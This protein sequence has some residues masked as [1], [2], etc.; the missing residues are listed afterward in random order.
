MVLRCL[1]TIFFGRSPR[2]FLPSF[3]ILKFYK[4]KIT[5][6][7]MRECRSGQTG[8]AQDLVAQC[9]RRF[10]PC[11]PHSAP[12]A[13]SGQSTCLLSKVSQVQILPGALKNVQKKSHIK[14]P[15]TVLIKCPF[16]GKR[17][18][19]KTSIER[20]IY[21]IECKGCKKKIQTPIT[22]C[23]LIC[24]FSNKKCPSSLIREAK[25]K[26]LKIK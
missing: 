14:I 18:R 21:F 24:A 3:L 10:E 23:C 13:Q 12:V 5:M 22:R 8:Q 19:I 4:L 15:K 7:F 17:N 26:N 16:C 1:L 25:T 11:L 20:Q 9:L 2:S 6:I